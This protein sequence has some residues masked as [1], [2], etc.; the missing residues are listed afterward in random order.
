MQNFN[1]AGY[2]FFRD[3]TFTDSL[4][5]FMSSYIHPLTQHVTRKSA[6]SLLE[7]TQKIVNTAP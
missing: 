3:T 5:P 7:S 4:C 6:M 2:Q 1:T